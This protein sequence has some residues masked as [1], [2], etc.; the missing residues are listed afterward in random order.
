M[1]AIVTKVSVNKRQEKLFS[2]V[3]NMKLM[4][5][6]TELLSKDF[7]ENYRT[8]NN[9]SDIVAKLQVDMQAAIDNYSSEQAIFNHAQMDTAVTILQGNLEVA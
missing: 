7:S 3:L 6:E 1:T 2:I 9:V 4:D 8:G 5:G